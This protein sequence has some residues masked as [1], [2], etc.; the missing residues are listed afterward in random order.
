MTL[1]GLA[2]FTWWAG[3]DVMRPFESMFLGG[4]VS[5]VGAVAVAALAKSRWSRVAWAATALATGASA[6]LC[7]SSLTHDAYND[8]VRRGEDVRTALALFRRDEGRYPQRLAELRAFRVPG[9]RWLRANLLNYRAT[10]TGYDLW[11][12]DWLVS[13]TASDRSGFVAHK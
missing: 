4:A 6:F 11:F 5:V 8:C 7:A 9:R 1:L 13:D 3:E 10:P 2:L 12:T